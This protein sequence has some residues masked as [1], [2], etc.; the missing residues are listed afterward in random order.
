MR[1]A[2][3]AEDIWLHNDQAGA[4]HR[5][6]QMHVCELQHAWSPHYIL[7]NKMTEHHVTTFAHPTCSQTSYDK[8]THA[9]NR[10]VLIMRTV[11]CCM[12]HSSDMSCIV[13]LMRVLLILLPSRHT[14]SKS[15][16]NAPGRFQTLYR[17]R[18]RLIIYKYI[19][20]YK[21]AATQY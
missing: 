8:A 12:H 13:E 16:Q 11:M 17:V 10:V 4:G 15:N 5:L 18:V 2:L 14:T 19:Q 20:K 9:V 6:L 7:D 1:I 21:L 3:K